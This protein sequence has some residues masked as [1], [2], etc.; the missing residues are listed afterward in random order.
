MPQFAIG[1]PVETEEPVVEV[2]VETEQ[3]LPTGRHV[4]Q[5]VVVDDSGNESKPD[6]VEVIVRDS[7]LPTAVLAAPKQVEFGT[8][9][10]L[11]GEKSS[12]VPPGKVVRYIWTLVE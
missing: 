3:P 4:F 12:D 5:L 1:S 7:E 10:E 6:Q 11:N 2:T 8:S 9:F